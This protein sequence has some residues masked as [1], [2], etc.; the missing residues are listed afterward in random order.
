MT[1]N[2]NTTNQKPFL[3]ISEFN[4]VY[5]T[6]KTELIKIKIQENYALTDIDNEVYEVQEI[7]PLTTIVTYE[8]LLTKEFPIIDITTGEQTGE[9]KTFLSLFY[10]FASFL[11]YLQLQRDENE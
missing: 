11:R 5:S 8:D 10:E 4:G 9:I 2:Y 1:K 7:A 6:N 3:R